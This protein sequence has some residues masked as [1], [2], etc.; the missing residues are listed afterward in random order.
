MN[1]YIAIINRDFI[2]TLLVMAC[3]DVLLRRIGYKDFVLLDI[4]AIQSS[5]DHAC[6]RKLYAKRKDEVQ[7]ILFEC[8]PCVDYDKLQD[9]YQRAFRYCYH[10]KHKLCYYPQGKVI[11]PCKEASQRLFDWLKNEPIL[12]LYKGGTIEK[13]IANEMSCDTINI[14]CVGVGKAQSHDSREKVAF[15]SNIFT[16]IEFSSA[17]DGTTTLH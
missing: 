2:N 6:V 13:R 15:N 5:Q 14:E 8:T 17:W 12:I 9:K 7:E 3:D 10:R 11:Y 4:E 1:V 16:T